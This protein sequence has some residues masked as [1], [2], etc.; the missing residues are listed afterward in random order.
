M[1]ETTTLSVEGDRLTAEQVRL[2]L[3][4]IVERHD[5]EWADI[6]A[7][8]QEGGTGNA[9]N[10]EAAKAWG[11]LLDQIADYDPVSEDWHPKPARQIAALP[12]KGRTRE[13]GPETEAVAERDGY[14]LNVTWTKRGKDF[15]CRVYEP[16]MMDVSPALAD[17]LALT[18]EEACSALPCKGGEDA[19]GAAEREVGRYIYRRIEAL[20]GGNSAELNW[21]STVVS[22]VEEYGEEACGANE[23]AAF[24]TDAV[25]TL[26]G[27]FRDQK[28]LSEQKAG[29]HISTSKARA[30]CQGRASA[31]REAVEEVLALATPTTEPDTG[32]GL[33]EALEE[34]RDLLKYEV[35]TGTL[36]ATTMLSKVLAALSDTPRGRE[37]E[38]K[39]G[40][41]ASRDLKPTTVASSLKGS[42][43]GEVKP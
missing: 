1:T 26:L 14:F 19:V 42:D 6:G 12:C 2:I 21:L 10:R 34:V 4:T 28:D 38:G 30:Y 41:M 37:E 27:K 13:V 36:R 33:R 15:A 31:F 29:E 25:A 9:P 18:Y 5:E 40:L 16:Q 43:V 32:R 20:M 39:Q 22:S 7:F 3:P 8:H 11:A 35:P 23:L 17:V 24:P